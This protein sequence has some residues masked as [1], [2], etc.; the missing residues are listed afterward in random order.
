M[1]KRIKYWYL[2]RVKYRK[3]YNDLL[4]VLDTGSLP[5]A[6]EAE[7]VSTRHR[8]VADKI[9]L[10]LG[11]D[12]YFQEIGNSNA[13]RVKANKVY[14]NPWS[15]NNI[16][17]Q[18]RKIDP[19]NRNRIAVSKNDRLFLLDLNSKTLEFYIHLRKKK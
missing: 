11:E 14:S 2:T 6:W 1:I 8:D 3:E 9:I 16:E 7:E 5:Y 10:L 13:R 15:S 19:T 18:K 12:F 4:D 17:I